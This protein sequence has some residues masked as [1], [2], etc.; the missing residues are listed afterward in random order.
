MWIH[1][2]DGE[3][4]P[5]ASNRPL[6]RSRGT[7]VR[8]SARARSPCR[9]LKMPFPGLFVLQEGTTEKVVAPGLLKSHYSPTKPFT[10]SIPQASAGAAALVGV[11]LHGVPLKPP[12]CQRLI[13][14]SNN[15][16]SLEVAAHLFSV[17]HAME[18]DPEISQIYIEPVEEHGCGRAIMD[19]IKKAAVQIQTRSGNHVGAYQRKPG[20]AHPI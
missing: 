16:N 17:L 6:S 12:A 20:T 1:V 18:D 2:L 8:S 10:S 11:I 4:P 3:R 19:R 9:I 13:Y 14:T 7:T 5:W 15:H